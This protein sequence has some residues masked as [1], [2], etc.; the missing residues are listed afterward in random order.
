MLREI[1]KVL[2]S[3][4][5]SIYYPSISVVCLGYKRD[6][7]ANSLDGFGFLI[8]S[9]EGRKILGTLWDSSIFPNRSP[10]GYVLLR[11][12]LGGVRRSELAEQSEEKQVQLVMEEL[13]G[14]MGINVQPDFAKVYIHKK[15]IPQYFPGHEKKL[16]TING[17]VDRFKRMYITGNA[18]RGIGVND[19]IE[20]SDKLAER[21][22]QEI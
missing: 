20:N 15:G 7:I 21:I 17:I 18:Y 12:M 6:R 10:E 13:K 22:V 1:D 2:S 8:P 16:E 19:C 5:S 9:R 3:T 14:I 4:L 11:N